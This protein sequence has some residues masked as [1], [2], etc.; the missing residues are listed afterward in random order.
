MKGGAS[1]K[2]PDIQ[3]NPPPFQGG[4]RGGLPKHRT[5]KLQKSPPLEGD[6]GGGYSPK[7]IKLKGA[8]YRKRLR[9]RFLKFGLNGFLDYEIIEL[10]LTLGMPSLIIKITSRKL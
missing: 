4:V 8:G 6:L 9:E 3:K 7:M 10:L 1:I 5:A 2:I